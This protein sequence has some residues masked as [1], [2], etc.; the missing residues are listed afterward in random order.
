LR[1][2]K[3]GQR[4]R[5]ENHGED[6]FVVGTPP[7]LVLDRKMKLVEC[8]RKRRPA[9]PYPGWLVDV[10]QG[11]TGHAGQHREPPARRCRRGEDAD[12]RQG[13]QAVRDRHAHE[14]T[15]SAEVPPVRNRVEREV[16]CH[17]KQEGGRRAPRRGAYHG[18]GQHMI[19]HQHESQRTCSAAGGGARSATPDS[20]SVAGQDRGVAP[21][22]GGRAEL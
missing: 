20:V 6:E 11:S 15:V 12:G 2:L 5:A 21:H 16:R 7:R 14:L 1:A 9:E 19:G 17:A 13:R 3:K 10:R 4:R 22:F 18:T 8:A